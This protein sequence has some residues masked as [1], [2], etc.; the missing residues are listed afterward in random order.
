MIDPARRGLEED[1]FEEIMEVQP[2]AVLYISCGPRGLH[3]DLRVF[4][5][6]GWT[7]GF[8]EAYDMFP[9]TPHIETLTLLLPPYKCSESTWRI[10]TRR[11]L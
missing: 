1:V 9:Q 5:Q 10:P 4:L 3:R 2:I 7:I 6:A 8:M 11:T